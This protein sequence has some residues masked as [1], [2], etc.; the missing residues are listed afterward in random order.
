MACREI[1][2]AALAVEGRPDDDR[3]TVVV[4]L[5]GSARRVPKGHGRR[6]AHSQIAIAGPAA[7]RV[8]P[9]P[10]GRTVDAMTRGAD[11]MGDR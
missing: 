2:E 8:Q 7:Q 4:N 11:G 9:G 1:D 10:E 5:N 3:V 6:A